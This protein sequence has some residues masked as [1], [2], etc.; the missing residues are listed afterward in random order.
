MKKFSMLAVLVAALVSMF[1]VVGSAQAATWHV[2]PAGGAFTGSSATGMTY[3]IQ[4]KTMT[5]TTPTLSGSVTGSGGGIANG[6]PSAL[7]W[8][9]VATLTPSYTG[10]TNAGINYTWRCATE[11]TNTGASGYNG[12]VATTEAGSAG[13]ST[14]IQLTG[15]LC[16]IKPTA[17]P[18]NNCTTITGTVPGVYTNPA[19]LAAGTGAANKGS[20]T[21]NTTGQSLTAASAGSCI[22]SIGTGST[23]FSQNTYTVSGSPNTT[24]AAPDIW[25]S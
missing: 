3:K 1:A 16:T 15:I 8:N 25:A 4:G 12:G 6:P 21:V 14:K 24:V 10:C 9:A 7:P 5:C 23:T 11:N 19:T 2:S 18:S 13:L 22:A 17:T 20:L